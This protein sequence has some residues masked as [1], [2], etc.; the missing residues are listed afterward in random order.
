MIPTGCSPFRRRGPVFILG[1]TGEIEREMILHAYMA[2]ERGMKRDT[3]LR[4]VLSLEKW[5]I[6]RIAAWNA[7]SNGLSMICTYGSETVVRTVFRTTPFTRRQTIPC[8]RSHNDLIFISCNIRATFLNKKMR[9]KAT[10]EAQ[11]KNK[12][13]PWR[14]I[15][16]SK[17]VRH[18][19][20]SMN[21]AAV[22]NVGIGASSAKKIGSWDDLK[23]CSCFVQPRLFPTW[24]D[25]KTVPL[26]VV[27]VR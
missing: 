17:K 20:I 24:C 12:I 3:T 1:L 23:A 25:G 4:A 8:M 10:E 22:A 16:K 5:I 18:K 7:S 2:S 15:R 26:Q 19:K 11:N 6:P 14:K 27:L 9:E 21:S 13:N